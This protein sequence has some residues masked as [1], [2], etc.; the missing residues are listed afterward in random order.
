MLVYYHNIHYT[1]KQ[2]GAISVDLNN[3][4]G[5]DW[6]QGNS[7]KNYDKHQVTKAEC[8]QLFFNQPLLMEF[9]VKHSTEEERY[10]VL[11]QTDATRKLCLIIVM[12]NN[13]IRVISAR[14][15]SK[16]ERGSY[17]QKRNT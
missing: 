14:D 1:L 2:K 5:F 3:I 17:E 15:M 9:D 11:G 7:T 10:Y 6:D 13:L 4:T 12:R 16:R 8:E